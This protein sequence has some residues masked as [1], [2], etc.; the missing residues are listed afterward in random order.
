MNNINILQEVKDVYVVHWWWVLMLLL[1]RCLCFS[2]V[3]GFDVT[4]CKMFMLFIGGALI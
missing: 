1:V 3:V 2:L 4:S